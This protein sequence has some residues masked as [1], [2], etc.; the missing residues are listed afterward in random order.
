MKENLRKKHYHFC[1]NCDAEKWSFILTLCGT[2]LFMIS[3]FVWLYVF[4]TGCRTVCAAELIG[5]G[6]VFLL[7]FFCICRI[8]Y[9]DR[10]WRNVGITYL[11][12]VAASVAVLYIFRAEIVVAPQPQDA[13]SLYGAMQFLIYLLTSAI[14]AFIPTL[15]DCGLIWLIMKL[16]GEE[17]KA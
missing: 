13:G 1:L 10:F 6:L 17:K 4:L 15:L 12:A 9:E 3:L 2:V 14:M 5:N 16:F 11:L 7:N 8:G